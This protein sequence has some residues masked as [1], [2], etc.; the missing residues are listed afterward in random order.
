MCQ[1]VSSLACDC[2]QGKLGEMCPDK[3]KVLRMHHPQALEAAMGI[4]RRCDGP[5]VGGGGAGA[6]S[7]AAG[8]GAGGA[9][10]VTPSALGRATAGPYIHSYISEPHKVY[11]ESA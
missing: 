3:A 11:L 10:A 8:K 7:V 5:A 4:R 9:P 6:G 1:L 2:T